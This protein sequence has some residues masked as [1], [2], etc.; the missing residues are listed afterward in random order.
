MSRAARLLWGCAGLAA[1]V[2]LALFGVSKGMLEPAGMVIFDSRV[3]GYEPDEARR[4]LDGL[5]N[6]LLGRSTYLGIFR[7]LDTV[8]PLLLT[9]CLS[10]AI[11]LNTFCWN[12]V[13]RGQLRWCRPP[14]CGRI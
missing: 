11:W 12:R 1:L 13:V 2:F 10:G 5:D 3:W 8:F 9:I 14:I 7:A 4:Y 6:M